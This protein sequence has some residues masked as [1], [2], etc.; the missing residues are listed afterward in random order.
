MNKSQ[1]EEFMTLAKPLIKFLNDNLHPHVLIVIDNGRA[2]LL[3]GL[4]NFP[5]E[6]FIKD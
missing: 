2:E 6:E 1:Q 3:E 5:C 4:F